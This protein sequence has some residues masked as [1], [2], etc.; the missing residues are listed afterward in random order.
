MS[1]VIGI[2]EVWF[3]WGELDRADLS[4]EKLSVSEC[5][6]SKWKLHLHG[7]FEVAGSRMIGC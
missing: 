3:E 7:R 2:E 6:E 1:S 5:P 4:I